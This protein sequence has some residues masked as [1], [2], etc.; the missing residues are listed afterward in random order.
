MTVRKE[1]EESI[2]EIPEEFSTA[3]KEKYSEIEEF[4][5]DAEHFEN[6]VN[7]LV[8]FEIVLGQINQIYS[9][10]LY[11]KSSGTLIDAATQAVETL[12]VSFSDEFV[13]QTLEKKELTSLPD[14]PLAIS[15][16]TE[17]HLNLIKQLFTEDYVREVMEPSYLKIAEAIVEVSGNQQENVEDI[18]VTLPG[19]EE[20]PAS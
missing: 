12:R 8:L 2:E 19:E 4:C 16:I 15:W 17:S 9:D 20:T 3:V 6:V 11:N 5:D 18:E 1:T 14:L 10:T 13:S 7:E